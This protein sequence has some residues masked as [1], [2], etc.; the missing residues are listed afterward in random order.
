VISQIL[1]PVALVGVEKNLGLL[2]NY[3]KVYNPLG[4]INT[5]ST[6]AEYQF[7]NGHK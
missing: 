5:A 1:K 4:L 3:L 2:K 6:S 7:S